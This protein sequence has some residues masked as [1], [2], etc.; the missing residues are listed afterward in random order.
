MASMLAVAKSVSLVASSSAASE[1]LSS[2]E[3]LDAELVELDVELVLSSLP[4]VEIVGWSFSAS[5]GAG[6]LPVCVFLAP[7]FVVGGS[8]SLSSCGGLLYLRVAAVAGR[9]VPVICVVWI[10]G[11]LMLYG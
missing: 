2:P 11:V 3:V 9:L 10:V 4:S 8:F 7:S 1:G 5:A 6:L